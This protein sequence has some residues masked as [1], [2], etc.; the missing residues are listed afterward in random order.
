MEEFIKLFADTLEITVDIKMETSLT[1]LAEWDSLGVLSVVSVIDDKYGV[2]IPNS[3]LQDA[4]SIKDLYEFIC[5][6][7]K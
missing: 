5:E 2:I 1:D 3:V 6:Q 7:K 4:R